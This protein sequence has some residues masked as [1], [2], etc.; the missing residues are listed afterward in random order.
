[1]S[2]DYPYGCKTEVRS[3]KE[4]DPAKTK[5]KQIKFP[6]IFN[7]GKQSKRSKNVPIFG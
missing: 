1:M 7:F 6:K 3:S 5:K 2:E 4:F